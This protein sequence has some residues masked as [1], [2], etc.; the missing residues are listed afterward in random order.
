M[1]FQTS[2]LL[3]SWVAILLLAL[4]VSGLVR[5]VHGLTAG[6][7]PAARGIGLPAGTPAPDFD[8]L[9][10]PSPGPLVLLFAGTDCRT[11]AALLPSAVAMAGPGVT[12]RV[13]YPDAV[14]AGAPS[15]ARGGAADL[16][17]SYG[18]IATPFG[19]LVDATG[20]VRGCVPVGS[21]DALR[22]LLGTAD[23]LLGAPEGA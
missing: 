13:L 8:L 1:S 21:V 5:Q 20:R 2:A 6:A 22:R 12:L 23:E 17:R 19:V 18:V 10:P 3:L 11:C 9:A 16:F 14:P 4:V 7:G 15:A